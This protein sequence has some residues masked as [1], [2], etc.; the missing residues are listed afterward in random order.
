VSAHHQ[1]LGRIVDALTRRYARRCWWV[2]VE[3][4]RQVAW[5]HALEALDRYDPAEGS[6]GGF[7]RRRVQTNLT[8][9]LLLQ[10]TPL[11]APD[12]MRGRR[13]LVGVRRAGLDAPESQRLPAD[14]P[15]ADAALEAEE[16]RRRLRGALL[17]A[18]G[19]GGESTLEEL[20]DALGQ[21]TP[22]RGT[23]LERLRGDPHLRAL[24]EDDDG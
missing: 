22:A 11:S 9:F 14:A 2:S 3:E 18:L 24:W 16:R 6:V 10:G 5:T 7:F 20:L 23:V 12:N 1:E 4:L 21:K 17:A 13:A 19:A 8:K 15:S